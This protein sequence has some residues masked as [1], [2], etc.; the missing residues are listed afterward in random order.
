MAH[1]ECPLRVSVLRRRNFDCTNEGVTSYRDDFTLFPS[2]ATY[3]QERDAA[4]TAGRYMTPP[5]ECL[6]LVSRNLGGEYLHAEPLEKPKDTVGPMAGGNFIWTSDGRFPNRYPIAV[7]D[8][9][10]TPELARTL[11]R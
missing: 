7:H 1:M 8:R 5:G 6:V 3:E 4:H 9:F 11:S 10:E 2:R